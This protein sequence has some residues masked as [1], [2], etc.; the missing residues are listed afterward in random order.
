MSGYTKGPWAWYQ[1]QSSGS[2]NPYGAAFV[3]GPKRVPM[4]KSDGFTIADARLIAA[5]PDIFEA[6]EKFI[7]WSGEPIGTAEF[8]LEIARAAI[9]KAKGEKIDVEA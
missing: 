7:V 3:I 9:A 6:L 5:A 1:P 2:L 8:P 4:D